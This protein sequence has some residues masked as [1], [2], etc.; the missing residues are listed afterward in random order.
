MKK[1][2]IIATI[3][4][5][6]LALGG[7]SVYAAG[8]IARSNAITEE[9]ACNFA[10]V[11]AAVLPEKVEQ[12]RVSFGFEDGRFVYDVTFTADGVRYAYTVD[13]TNGRIVE[14]EIERLSDT[15]PDPVG[16][17]DEAAVTGVEDA[18]RI[19]LEQAGVP[20]DNVT[21]YKAQHEQDDGREVYDIAFSVGSEAAYE[22]EIDAANG[23]VLEKQWKEQTTGS[24]PAVT[25]PDGRPTEQ[26][27]QPASSSS[28]PS[29]SSA[30][31]AETDPAKPVEMLT[32]EQ[33]K[34]VA[35]QRA[36]EAASDA[37]FTKAKLEY[38]DRRPVYEIAF[39]VAG[40]ATFEYEI[41]AYTAAV[42]EQE[43]KPWKTDASSKPAT[44]AAES[45]TASQPSDPA[46]TGGT[47]VLPAEPIT[48]EE[49][50][51]IALRQAGRA[52]GDVVFS[53][54]KLDH[55]DGR[56]IYEIEFYVAG[57]TEYEYEIDAYSGAVLNEETEPWDADD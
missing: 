1:T 47:A 26:P 15:L 53:K 17:P 56:L 9:T 42:R 32:V 41:D 54:A 12:S 27:Q 29:V 5:G 19:A 20:G 14:K 30:S 7:G 24:R 13:S 22:Y 8:Q 31:A 46:A 35:L 4:A 39:Y 3:A 38:D 43:M 28:A 51:A 25:E 52:V 37:V 10:Y 55:D 2:A 16:R 50:K 6:V 23:T 48:V 57:Q 33:A 21:F 36:G 11:D 44:S 34:A 18:K 45:G 40:K 49:A